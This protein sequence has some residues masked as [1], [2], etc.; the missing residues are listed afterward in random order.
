MNVNE[1]LEGLKGRASDLLKQPDQA[2]SFISRVQSKYSRKSLPRF[3]DFREDMELALGMM[4]DVIKRRY[5]KV[6]W[7]SLLIVVG[8][9]IYFLN[10]FDIV[11]DFIPLKGLLDDA[12]VLVYVLKAVHDDLVEY[13]LWRKDSQR[14]D[15]TPAPSR[16][17]DA[18]DAEWQDSSQ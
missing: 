1:I 10:P 8:A 9:F 5:T 4:K 2:M 16:D 14:A 3:A 18:E 17:P 11:P 15:I 6:P 7:Q 12:T 13:D